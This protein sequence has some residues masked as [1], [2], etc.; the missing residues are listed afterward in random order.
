M[1]RPRKDINQGQFEGLCRIQC[2]LSEIADIFDCSEDTIERWCRR[3]YKISFAEAFK[4]FSA[5]G[6]MS[7]R[8]IQ[9]KLAEKSPAMAIW[10]GKQ[11]LGQREFYEEQ[12]KETDDGFLQALSGTAKDDWNEDGGV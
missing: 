9:F 10:L 7:L 3:E 4:R 6:K 2:T 1:A 11:Y 12:V 8:R 5:G